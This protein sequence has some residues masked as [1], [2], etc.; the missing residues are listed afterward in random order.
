MYKVIIR[1]KD[2][3][4]DN[5]VYNVG[6]EFPR[7]GAKATKKRINELA[8]SANLR[9]KPLIEKV[10]ETENDADGDLSGDTELV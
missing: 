8:S 6:D 4:D 2:L 7:K 1:F 5:Y 3:Q 9:K 10:E